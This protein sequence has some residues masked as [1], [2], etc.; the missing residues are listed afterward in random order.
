MK[1]DKEYVLPQSMNIRYDVLSD[2]VP[3]SL[4]EQLDLFSAIKGHELDL[5]KHVTTYT[6]G[7]YCGGELKKHRSS[8]IIFYCDP[9]EEEI[10]IVSGAETDYCEYMFTVKT[11]YLCPAGRRLGKASA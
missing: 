1:F 3:L 8:K 4:I 5:F 2:S 10:S 11:K 9:S 7:T 6:D